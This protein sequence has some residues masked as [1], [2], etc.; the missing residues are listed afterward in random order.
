MGIKKDPQSKTPRSQKE[1][2][3]HVD[4]LIS[5]L[6]MDEAGGIDLHGNNKRRGTLHVILLH[7]GIRARYLLESWFY[8]RPILLSALSGYP[9][10]LRPK[11]IP[12]VDWPTLFAI[13]M[14]WLIGSV[15]RTHKFFMT[16]MLKLGV[17][18]GLQWIHA[19]LM[20]SSWQLQLENELG[21]NTRALLV[22]NFRT[23]SVAS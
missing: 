8:L 10:F 6:T 3:V 15:V 4:C 14:L 2:V 7:V 13:R 22:L 5:T 21:T 1:Y 19:R 12:E 20:V 18:Q 11:G 9:S 17:M 23:G 16:A